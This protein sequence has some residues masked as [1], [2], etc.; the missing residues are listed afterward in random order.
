MALATCRRECL[1]KSDGQELVGQPTGRWLAV[2][3]DRVLVW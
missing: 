1:Q 3:E 2:Y